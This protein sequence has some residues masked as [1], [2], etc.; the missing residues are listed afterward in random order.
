MVELVVDHNCPSDL[1]ADIWFGRMGTESQ[2][3]Y[4]MFHIEG[5]ELLLPGTQLGPSD[6]VLVPPGIVFQYMDIVFL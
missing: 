4:T 3:K 6:I 2:R 1:G 5:I